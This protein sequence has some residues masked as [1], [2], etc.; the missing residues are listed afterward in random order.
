MKD[1]L[2]A[3]FK[4]IRNRNSGVSDPEKSHPGPATGSSANDEMRENRSKHNGHRDFP[5]ER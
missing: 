5:I 4:T 3:Y 1:D 2:D